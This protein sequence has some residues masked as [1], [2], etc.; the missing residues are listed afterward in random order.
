MLKG[1]VAKRY[2]R[3]VFELGVEGNELDKWH[4]DL[5]N[6]SAAV[7]EPDIALVLANN[8]VPLDTRRQIM[9]E[10]LPDVSENA[11]NLTSLLLLKSRIGLVESIL[12]EFES[13]VNAHKGI[14][15]ARVTT[16]VPLEEKEKEALA[17]RLENVTGKKIILET[18]VDAEIIGGM[19][20]RI[21]DK[22]IDGSTRTRLLA[23]KRSLAGIAR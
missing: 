19:I 1:G 9:A 22:V 7:E 5:K 14:E 23:L 4:E 10:R 21:G 12:G 3:A 16:A 17:T 20:A 18:D 2:A 8:K 15:V 6:I 13:L 11:L